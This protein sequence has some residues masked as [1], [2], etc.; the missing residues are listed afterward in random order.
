MQRMQRLVSFP[1]FLLFLL[2]GVVIGGTS[3]AVADVTLELRL[4][5]SVVYTGRTAE[6]E[7]YAVGDSEPVGIVRAVIDWDP[8]KLELLPDDLE[9]PSPDPWQ[10]GYFGFPGV[11]LNDDY[12]D[13]KAY[14]QANISGACNTV[15]ATA[16]GALV[17]TMWFAALETTVPTTDVDI[18]A[19]YADG[20]G[21]YVTEVWDDLDLFC[22]GQ[23]YLTTPLGDPVSLTIIACL[24]AE[25]CD[26]G[27]AC[28][29]DTCVEGVCTYTPEYLVGVECCD[30]TD[31]ST[32]LIDDENECTTDT[33]N[34]D[35]GVVTHSNKPNGTLCDAHLNTTCTPVHMCDPYGV[36][37]P[38]YATSGSYC[39]DGEDCTQSDACDG[40]GNCVGADFLPNGSA[41]EDGEDCT[42]GE[43]CLEGVCQGGT[44]PCSAPA[45]FCD[46]N[47]V[48]E[49][50]PCPGGQE[51]CPEGWE[52]IAEVCTL[53][54]RCLECRFG[55]GL[56][57]CPD[58]DGDCLQMMCVSGVC[59]EQ[60]PN[61]DLC[62][63][64][65]YC[66]GREW[67][68]WV[69]SEG[70]CRDDPHPDPC[71]LTPDTPYCDEANDRCVE[72]LDSVHCDTD[73][74][75]IEICNTATGECEDNPLPIDC[76]GLDDVCAAGACNPAT[77]LCETTPL[78]EI[79]CT[80][81]ADCSFYDPTRYSCP[82]GF[83]A[84]TE[85][86]DDGNDC[87][88][89]DYC[90][91][92]VCVGVPPT[93]DGPVDLL[94]SPATQTVDIGDPVY[95]DLYAALNTGSAEYVN[96]AEVVITWDPTT[97]ALVGH[98]D[99]CTAQPCDP[100][101]YEWGSSFFPEGG[102]GWDPDNL[103]DA[104]VIDDDCAEGISCVSGRCNDGD[105]LYIALRRLTDPEGAPVTSTDPLWITTVEFAAAFPT[106]LAGTD[107]D[108]PGCLLSTITR[109]IRTGGGGEAITGDLYSATVVIGCLTDADCNDGNACTDDAC[110]LDSTCSFTPNY[111]V[112][113][114]CCN[115]GPDPN[116][117]GTPAGG[118]EIIDDGNDC[119]TDHCNPET[120][121][122]THTLLPEGNPCGDP[123][124]TDCDNPD[125]CDAAG[126]CLDNFEPEGVVCP[127][128]G[129]DCTDDECDGAGICGHPNKAVGAPC[130][131][132]DDTECTDPDACDGAGTCLPN[133][134]DPGTPCGDA[135]EEP[136]DHADTC[137]GSGS[138]QPNYEPAEGDCED[139]VFCNGVDTCDGAGIC[140]RSGPPCDYCE[141]VT[142]GDCPSGE[143]VPCV[144]CPP[145]SSDICESVTECPS[146]PPVVAA[147][148]CRY[149]AITP[150]PVDSVQPMKLII[151]SPDFP[152]LWDYVV[153]PLRCGGTGE[154]CSSDAECNACSTTGDPCVVDEDCYF[155]PQGEFCVLSGELCEPGAVVPIDI[156]GDG[157][158]DGM[159]GTLA[160]VEPENATTL[161]PADWGADLMRCSK[162]IAVCV[163]DVDCDHGVCVHDFC[164][165]MPC[166]NPC[167]VSGQ[168]C[169]RF[170][171]QTQ[172]G[173]VEDVD[174]P[175]YPTE[176]CVIP[177]CTRDET[178]IPGRVYVA[179]ADLVP[180]KRSGGVIP[181]T[182]EV[183]VDYGGGYTAPVSVETWVWTDVNNDTWGNFTDVQMVVLAFQGYYGR[184]I[185]MPNTLVGTDFV[186]GPSPCRPEQMANFNDVA[187][188]VKA[189]QGEDYAGRLDAG[190]CV[191]NGRV[192]SVSA[193]NCADLT[194]CV[195]GHDCQMPC[196][197]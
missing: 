58:D 137:D 182:Y 186:S 172:Y 41:C 50:D 136:C 144:N 62:A 140:E 35:T 24:D 4:P 8:V 101:Q 157:N 20:T 48:T 124:D 94:W 31:G 146:N 131:N 82:A 65:L 171:S 83:C 191:G 72:C 151:T 109:I 143:C 32:E 93:T 17:A 153:G 37:Q 36:C 63:D 14:F 150:M 166:N 196:S 164:E 25:D 110:E 132:Q 59:L 173:C 111:V 197:P 156:N 33:C 185:G 129:N 118:V 95:V 2:C 161:I 92:G 51:D 70:I 181:T 177:I 28:T 120:G 84:P 121:Y 19:S 163:E 96:S 133:D 30:P 3:P 88:D 11:G 114:E 49:G 130:G 128:E 100:G 73:L 6:V 7:L 106:G 125:T 87:T 127:D 12:S 97:L 167:S 104:C 139:G 54:Y 135:T 194:E 188:A 57:D 149:L 46:P 190:T 89:P 184:G 99:P 5:E 165:T 152:C 174:C 134:E 80:T 56:I 168:N 40:A 53:P 180:S 66:N 123:S 22:G 195:S 64:G 179:G 44:D 69:G 102:S 158:D 18:L 169:S 103:N 117:H 155:Y 189:F 21:T 160:D 138:C 71:S 15:T 119:T 193:Q 39:N 23:K 27:D 52:C 122:V 68:E 81:G 86:C 142:A 108:I 90:E 126:N 13:G 67:C 85:P 183:R 170:C 45:P 145:G 79:F 154:S 78:E 115:P 42:V 116:A 107:V 147:V 91:G 148:G 16:E 26:D 55:L 9:P 112:S 178:C 77:G 98:Q 47:Q 105:A 75:L 159:L 74:C 43:E 10:G 38:H 162:S 29:G 76:S 141:C 1:T 34:P 61:D 176:T 175:S 60:A 113:V 187:A 192:C